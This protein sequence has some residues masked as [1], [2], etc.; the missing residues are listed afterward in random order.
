MSP[1][2]PSTHRQIKNW[3]AH[4]VIPPIRHDILMPL[5]LEFVVCGTGV[6][7]LHHHDGGE[8]EVV[9]VHVLL[10]TLAA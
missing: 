8:F 3:L 1:N 5:K 6:Q 7:W 4:R 9:E 2:D 10:S